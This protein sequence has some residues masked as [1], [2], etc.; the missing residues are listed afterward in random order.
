VK[1]RWLRGA[2][3]VGLAAIAMLASPASAATSIWQV[4]PTPNPAP[5]AVDNAF[6]TGVSADT[7]QDAWAVGIYMSPDALQHPL[8]EHWNGHRWRGVKVPEPTVRQ[9]WLLGVDALSAGNVWAVG[10]STNG[11][12]SNQDE[13]TFIEHWDGTTWTIVPSPNPSTG[14]NSGDFLQAVSGVEPGRRRRVHGRS[15]GDQRPVLFADPRPANLERVSRLSTAVPSALP[16]GGVPP[17]GIVAQGL[18]ER[19]RQS[20]QQAGQFHRQHELGRR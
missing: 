10:V 18:I 6:F 5:H 3:L 15:S 16:G 14:A 7:A 17:V 20:G 8:V 13:R 4:L 19:R 9:S 1:R 12:I 2:P 11:E